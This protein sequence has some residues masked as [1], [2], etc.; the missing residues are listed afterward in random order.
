MT[1]LYTLPVCTPS[2][3]ALLTGIYPYRYGLQRGYGDFTPNGLPTGLKLLPVQSVLLLS[4]LCQDTANISTKAC[5]L[6][7]AC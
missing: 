4:Y 2:R 1:S 3:A 5:V 6:W 7:I